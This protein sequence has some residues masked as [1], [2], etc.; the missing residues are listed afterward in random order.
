M[1]SIYLGDDKESAI[2]SLI[3]LSKLKKDCKETLVVNGAN[4]KQTQIYRLM[5]E[6]VFETKGV[7]GYTHALYYLKVDKAITAIQN[8]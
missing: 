8:F 6:T 7:A 4:N 2:K 1:H 3:D 5:G